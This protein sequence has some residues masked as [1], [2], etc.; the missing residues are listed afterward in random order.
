M[1]ASDVT[2]APKLPDLLWGAQQLRLSEFCVQDEVP[3]V[4]LRNWW[5]DELK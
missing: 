4:L 3:N 1:Q 2:I 5:K